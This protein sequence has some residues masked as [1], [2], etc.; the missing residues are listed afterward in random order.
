VG[1]LGKKVQV[2]AQREVILAGGV[3]NTPQLL[4]LSGIGPRE[5][6]ERPALNVPVLVDL[7]GVGKNL[8][9][10]YEVSV[11]TEVARPF[12]ATMAC[13]FDPSGSASDPC[14]N[15]LMS[16]SGPYAD[17]GVICGV[18]KRSNHAN[19]PDPDLFLFGVPAD[20]RGYKPGYSAGIPGDRKHF[21]WAVLKAHTANKTGS[22]TLTS[23]D[24][25]DV[26]HVAF[27]YFPGGKE[28]TDLAAVVDGVELAREMIRATASVPGMV[29]Q[30][31]FP[32][33]AVTTRD[34]IAEFVRSEAWGHHACGTCKMGPSKD[35]QAVVDG[36]FRVH[37]VAGLRVVDASIFP[38]APG[39][40]IATAVYM[41]SEKATDDVLEAHGR[42]RRVS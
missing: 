40:F 23:S 1:P 2:K 15:Q 36:Q 21:S 11:V 35:P 5:E 10:R 41:V 8:Q 22:V 31:V 42:P 30:E 16:G 24:P 6:L 29:L 9:D 38:D 28:D 7:P 19:T 25:R 27:R 13:T 4:M 26:P 3:F 12:L 34:Q 20:F 37:G 18:V 32:G 39:F 17:N 33:P 14:A